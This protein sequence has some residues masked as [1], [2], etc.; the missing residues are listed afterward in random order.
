MRCRPVAKFKNISNMIVQNIGLIIII[1]SVAAFFLPDYFKWMTKYTAVFL[2]VAMFGMGTSIDGQSFKEV[3]TR[4]KEVLIGCIAQY[5][6]MPLAAWFLAVSFGLNK[7]LA[8]GVILVGCCPGGT[9]GNV[10]THIAGGNVPM[11][12]AM[13][14]VSTLVAPFATPV[15]VYLLAGQWVQVSMLAMFK[16][17]VTVILIPV[18]LGIL[19]NRF[20]GSAVKKGESIFP[21]ISSAAIVL[22]ISGIIGAN[23]SKIMTCGLLVLAVVVVHNLIGLLGGLAIAKLFG[24]DYD[25][26][27]ALAIEVGMQNSGLAVSLAT[28]NF[29]TNPLATLPGAIFSIWHNLSGSIFA[30]LRRRGVKVLSKERSVQ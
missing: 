3:F 1:F 22:I 21:L 25:K 24:M 11:S 7:E 19:A 30:N 16:S 12:V 23:S 20:L 18:I 15:L 5:T 13:T 10:I 17:V 6:I 26:S 27:T 2:G 9:A 28:V 4:P 29:A 8:L 14:I